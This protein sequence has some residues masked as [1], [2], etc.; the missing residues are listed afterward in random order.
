MLD[1]KTN[2][3]GVVDENSKAPVIKFFTDDE[4]KEIEAKRVAEQKKYL[5]LMYGEDSS[6]R[7]YKMWEYVTGRQ[8]AYNYIRE[9]LIDIEEEDVTVDAYKSRIIV[10]SD[11]GKVKINGIS[12]YKFMKQMKLEGLVEDNTNFDIEE[13]A[14]DE[15]IGMSEDQ[16]N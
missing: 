7:E 16:Q 8:E 13:W 12:I 3:V 14:V 4:K 1:N 5:I 9:M 15:Q 10:E 2:Q 11:S 6:G